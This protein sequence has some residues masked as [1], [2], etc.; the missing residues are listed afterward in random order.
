MKF[1]SR[2]KENS[3]DIHEAGS[4]RNGTGD[5]EGSIGPSEDD[6][7]SGNEDDTESG[8]CRYN[9]EN[10]EAIAKRETRLVRGMRVLVM[11]ILISSIILLAWF[12]HK[13]LDAAE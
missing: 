13:Y 1:I 4:T 9:K 5:E 12:V 6:D 2:A 11:M 10:V 8:Q 7:Y 3:V